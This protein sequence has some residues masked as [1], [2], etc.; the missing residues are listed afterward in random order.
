MRHLK[1]WRTTN[2]H[3]GEKEV[4]CLAQ[5]WFRL[6]HTGN[7]CSPTSTLGF[8]EVRY[9]N[10]ET[11]DFLSSAFPNS[12]YV[13]N[14]RRDTKKQKQSGYFQQERRKAERI[15]NVTE[16]LLRFGEQHRD[17]SY[18]LPLED[19]RTE[20]FSDMFH[21]MGFSHCNASR[22]PRLNK[23]NSYSRV[24]SRPLGMEPSVRCK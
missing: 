13:I 11:L 3:V 23:S 20:K 14:F 10:E 16:T 24:P 1:A 8:K 9:A 12:R 21:W 5:R 2:D 4:Y 19:F 7:D 6:Q 22:L 15:D 18:F 17:V